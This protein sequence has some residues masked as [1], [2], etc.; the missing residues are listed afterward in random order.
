MRTPDDHMRA[1]A[2]EEGLAA[3]LRVA[4]EWRDMLELRRLR[5]EMRLTQSEVAKQASISQR[6]LSH[7]ETG[8]VYVRIDVLVRLGNVYGIDPTTLLQEANVL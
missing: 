2:R 1:F 8:K 4:E 7:V 3:A 6:H 5:L